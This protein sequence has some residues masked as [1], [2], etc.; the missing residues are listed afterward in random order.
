MAAGRASAEKRPG[1]AEDPAQIELTAFRCPGLTNR[2]GTQS[3]TRGAMNPLA[4]QPSAGGQ[5]NAISKSSA[6]SRTI[7]GAATGSSGWAWVLLFA[8]GFLPHS[9]ALHAQKTQPASAAESPMKLHYE[10]AFKFQDAGNLLRA[11]AEYKLYLSMALHRIAN[12]YANLGDYANAA[13][14]FEES[15]KLAPEDKELKIDYAAC[16]LYTSRCV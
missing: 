12:G 14:R 11:N 9:S 13:Q 6:G 10:A 16:L 3:A 2:I 1:S 15:L 5:T 8:A 7:A 4:P